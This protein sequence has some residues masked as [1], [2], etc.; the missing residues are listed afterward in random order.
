MFPEKC[1][2][3]TKKERCYGTRSESVDEAY[4]EAETSVKIESEMSK[5]FQ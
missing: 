5:S 3:G 4:N 1:L 2:V